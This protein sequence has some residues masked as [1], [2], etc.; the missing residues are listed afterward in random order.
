MSE[1]LISH[2]PDLKRLRDEGYAV[3][4][5]HGHLVVRSVPYANSRGEVAYGRVVTNL[6]LNGDQTHQGRHVSIPYGNFMTQRV[7]MYSY[8]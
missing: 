2:S 4:V 3:E 5:H 8:L 7:K 1:K 6:N